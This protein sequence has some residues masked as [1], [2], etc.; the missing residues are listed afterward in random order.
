M[1][2]RILGLDA[3]GSGVITNDT[4]NR[5]R[6]APA[7]WRGERR[8]VA[9]A[10][11]DFEPS[12]DGARDIYP[13]I[14]AMSGLRAAVDIEALKSSGAA[15]RI[16]SLSRQHAA[17]PVVAAVLVLVA[18][19]LPALSAP[20]LST[21][22]L[23]IDKVPKLL[24]AA[25]AM[26]GEDSGLGL[27]G[28]LLWLRYAAPLTAIAVIFLILTGRPH[29][30][31]PII[32]G[33]AALFA[34]AL[35]FLIKGAIIDKVESSGFGGAMRGSIDALIEVGPGAWLCLIAGAALIAAGMGVL[36]NPLATRAAA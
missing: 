5:F 12:D 36:K 2:G 21:T 9:G 18:F 27:A 32:A 8:P 34:G 16:Q 33:V 10:S 25:G 14:S 29:G 1:R 3:D 20:Q 15:S 31:A 19:L 26:M 6:F 30:P 7:D 28:S 11:V 23:N 22:L 17:V 13:A 35:P 24:G 4:G